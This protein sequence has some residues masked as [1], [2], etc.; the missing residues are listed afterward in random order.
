MGHSLFEIQFLPLGQRLVE[1]IIRHLSYKTVRE[2]QKAN[3][4]VKA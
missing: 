1:K 2:Y 3:S 4:E